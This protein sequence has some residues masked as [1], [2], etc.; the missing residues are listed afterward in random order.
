MAELYG[1]Y[2]HDLPTDIVHRLMSTR[3]DAPWTRMNLILSPPGGMS[4]TMVGHRWDDP[5]GRVTTCRAHLNRSMWLELNNFLNLFCSLI[6][7]LLG[8]YSA[9]LFLF[10]FHEVFITSCLVSTTIS[11]LCK[12]P[13]LRCIASL[14]GC[15]AGLLLYFSC[16]WAVLTVFCAGSCLA[17]ALLSTLYFR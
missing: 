1:K 2:T 8:L 16:C 17:R 12:G 15:E 7:A 6:Q 9:S 3:T 14:V 10:I 13:L 4:S 5:D 11:S